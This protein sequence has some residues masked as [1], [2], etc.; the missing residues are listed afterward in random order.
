MSLT[1]ARQGVAGSYCVD[2]LADE[3]RV[4]KET[5]DLHSITCVPTVPLRV[6]CRGDAAAC[7]RRGPVDKVYLDTQPRLAVEVGTRCTVYV[8]NS[9]GFTDHVVWH[10]WT[11]NA[12]YTNFMCVGSGAVG[13]PIRL[14]PVRGLGALCWQHASRLTPRVATTAV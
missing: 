11:K 10:P 4:K 3:R 9:E 6:R 13:R 2:K 14:A 8:E 1:R 5:Q 12:H 7:L